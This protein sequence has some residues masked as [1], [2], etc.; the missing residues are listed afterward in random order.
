MD[1]SFFKKFS[2][3]PSGKNYNYFNHSYSYTQI[4][5]G[6]VKKNSLNVIHIFN[7]KSTRR[8]QNI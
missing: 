5:H 1:L 2:R 8:Q 4:F 3:V 6:V 7:K